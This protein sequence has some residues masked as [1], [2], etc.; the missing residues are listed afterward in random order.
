MKKQQ[1]CKR[2]VV[3]REKDL[4]WVKGGSGYNLA[5]GRE[6]DPTDPPPSGGGG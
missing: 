6:E 2:E 3:V 4:V 1:G 5:T